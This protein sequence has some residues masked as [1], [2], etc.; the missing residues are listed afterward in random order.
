[1]QAFEFAPPLQ[2][3]A[4]I[5]AVRRQLFGLST[6]AFWRL[7]DENQD[8]FPKQIDLGDGRRA[9]F[10]VQEILNWIQNRQRTR[11]SIKRT[12]ARA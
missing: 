12:R 1:M 5:G 4:S 9:M 3:M 7:R 2:G 6:S 10:D 8:T 11:S